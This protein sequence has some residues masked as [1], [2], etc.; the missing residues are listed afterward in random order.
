M[1]PAK[2]IL[3]SEQ[4][5]TFLDSIPLR[6]V[7]KLEADHRTF[8]DRHGHGVSILRASGTPA[9]D[10]PGVG[11]LNHPNRPHPK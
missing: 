2:A 3:S 1:S 9:K 7:P 10:A 8:D 11:C 4:F 5:M 6:T